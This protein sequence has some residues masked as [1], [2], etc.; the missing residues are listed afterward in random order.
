[1]PGDVTRRPTMVQIQEN[2]LTLTYELLFFFLFK[3]TAHTKQIH[4]F[5]QDQTVTPNPTKLFQQV[6]L[7]QA[8][9][10]WG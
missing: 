3:F 4:K 1:M 2:N 5:T 10:K 6:N 7:G 8:K 9:E